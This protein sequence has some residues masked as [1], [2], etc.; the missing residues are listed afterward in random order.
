[1]LPLDF[2]YSVSVATG[3]DDGH[4]ASQSRVVLNRNGL[5]PNGNGAMTA[6][7]IRSADRTITSLS[8]PPIFLGVVRA[9]SFAATSV[10]HIIDPFG[11]MREPG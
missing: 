5:S 1:M 4:A 11:S 10:V 7:G 2:R 3:V 9:N 8:A 6:I